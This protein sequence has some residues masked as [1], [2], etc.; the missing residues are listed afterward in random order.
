MQVLSVNVARAEER[1]IPGRR[2]LTAI[3]KRPRWTVRWPWARWG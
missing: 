2:E 1:D 3:G